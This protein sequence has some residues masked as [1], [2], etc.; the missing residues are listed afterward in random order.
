VIGPVPEGIRTNFY[1]T[2]GEVTGPK[3]YGKVLSEGGD[4]LILRTDGVGILDVR[5]TF[6]TQD[7]ALIDVTYRGVGDLGEDGYE[8]FLRG[9]LPTIVS[10]RVVPRF[11]TAN[12]DYQW[13]NR[14]QCVGIGEVNLESLEV[15]Y[16]VYALG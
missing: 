16:D 4:W 5:A 10:L 12:P 3:I 11:Q 8:R 15:T 14:L 7:E 6:E 13:L 1:V 9:E 2:S